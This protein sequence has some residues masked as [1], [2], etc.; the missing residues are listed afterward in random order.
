M[1]ASELISC[2]VVDDEFPA[3]KLLADYVQK[4]AGLELALKTT[5]A[6]EALAY[7]IANKVDLLFLDIQMPEL[8]GLELMNIIKKTSTKVILT[9]AYTEYAVAGFEQDAADYLLKPITLERFLVSVGK[10]A[11]RINT[12]KA[13]ENKGQLQSAPY[14]FVKTEYRIQKIVLNS[15]M[16]IEGLGDYI[17]LHTTGGKILSLERMKNIEEALPS[18][19]FIRAHKSY[20]INTDHIDFIEKGRIIINKEYL[21]IGES[22]KEK[23]W[24]Q[25]GLK[26]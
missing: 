18:A 17:A 26:K 1:K 25:L 8:S 10:V 2:V 14:I 16:Y 22:Y 15:I 7:T 12:E 24:Q 5:S 19:N 21:P 11:A 13:L 23:I 9:T 3:V 4:T 6:M 20:I